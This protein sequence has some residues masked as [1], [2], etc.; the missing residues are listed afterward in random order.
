[1][2]KGG[3]HDPQVV[4]DG[5]D[6]CARAHPLDRHWDCPGPRVWRRGVWGRPLRRIRAR[7]LRRIRWFLSG[8]LRIW[9]FPVL[10][11]LLLIAY[12]FRPETAA[13]W[14]A[15]APVGARSRVSRRRA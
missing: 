5:C 13:P 4:A 11:L 6:R 2:S 10:L 9:L 14:L 8:L 7:L 3:S 12:G 1:M 15:R